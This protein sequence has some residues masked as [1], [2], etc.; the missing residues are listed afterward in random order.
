MLRE[1]R[2]NRLLAL[3]AS[4]PPTTRVLRS[5]IR[6]QTVPPTQAVKS[7]PTRRRRRAGAD[8]WSPKRKPNPNPRPRPPPRTHF[9]CRICIEEQTTDQFVK[10]IPARPRRAMWSIPWDVPFECVTHLARNPNRRKVD[11]VCKTCVGRAMSAR[12]DQ[13]GARQVGVGCLL[14]GCRT[15]W[16]WDF[17]MRYMPA[18]AL[19]KYNMEMFDVWKNDAPI[20]PVTCISTGCNAIGLPDPH[21]PGYP[22]VACNTCA[23][24]FCAVCSIPWHRDVTCAE[25]A[26]KQVDDKMSDPEK[27]TLKLMQTKDGK[28]CPNCY[29][30]IEKEGGCDSMFC[31]GCKKYFNWATAG[32]SYSLTS[33]MLLTDN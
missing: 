30:V 26:A 28:R 3:R 29:L 22:Q 32:I 12:L 2:A 24:R 33:Y 6:A 7:Q 20:K 14:P 5:H 16:N 15:E 9:T 23:F 10:W 13:L 19:E 11:P 8:P 21:A 25:H 27:E 4:L 1:A 31:I 18:E 17:V